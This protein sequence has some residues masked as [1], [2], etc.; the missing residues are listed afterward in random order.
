MWAIRPGPH[1]QRRSRRLHPCVEQGEVDERARPDFVAGGQKL[2]LELEVSEEAHDLAGN[3]G[4]IRHRSGGEVGAWGRILD[5][6]H[7][8]RHEEEHD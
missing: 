2:L 8:Q 1:P 3:S 4:V 7:Y 6:Q 5:D